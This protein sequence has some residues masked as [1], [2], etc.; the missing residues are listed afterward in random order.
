MLI[1]TSKRG[2]GARRRLLG[3]GQP[4]SSLVARSRIDH[5][6]VELG[7]LCGSGEVAWSSAVDVISP[8]TPSGAMSARSMT[9]IATHHIWGR[10]GKKGK[11]AIGRI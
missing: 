3:Q 6:L 11:E 10:R 1:A 9:T 7:R 2:R 5:G 8:P 4:R